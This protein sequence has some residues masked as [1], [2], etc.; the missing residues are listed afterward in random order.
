MTKCAYRPALLTGL[1]ML[2]PP[3]A[4]AGEKLTEPVDVN[5]TNPVVQVEVSNA[6]PVPVSGTVT[7]ADNPALQP[8]SLSIG[9]AISSTN[10]GFNYFEG[11]VFYTVPEGKRL[12]IE[13]L[14]AIVYAFP[15]SNSGQAAV[16]LSGHPLGITS[17]SIRCTLSQVCW[18]LNSPTRI[19]LSAGESLRAALLLDV[20]QAGTLS[21]VRGSVNGHLVDVP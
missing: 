16:V 9:V 17:E 19:Y 15:S 3:V 2:L 20:T 8:V 6:D 4:G 10:V 18:H 1:L 12:V 21:F 14:D 5:I 7:S 11:P 13:Y